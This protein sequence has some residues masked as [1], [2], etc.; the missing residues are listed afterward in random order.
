MAMYLKKL[1]LYPKLKH[2]KLI[3]HSFCYMD[4]F[5]YYLVGLKYLILIFIQNQNI[6]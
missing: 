4:F 2:L 1:K 5:F 3:V 6:Q